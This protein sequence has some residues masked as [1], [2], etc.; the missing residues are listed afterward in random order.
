MIYNNCKRGIGSAMSTTISI[1]DTPETLDKLRSSTFWVNYFKHI[2][3]VSS[4]ENRVEQLDENILVAVMDK[5][6]IV[7]EL[8]DGK[9][10]TLFWY[11]FGVEDES[12]PQLLQDVSTFRNIPVVLRYVPGEDTKYLEK[13]KH[14]LQN[15]N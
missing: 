4:I 10:Y 9:Y 12:F 3:G 14:G 2:C 8:L 13:Y 6:V 1:F 5:A 15:K 11:G 7:L